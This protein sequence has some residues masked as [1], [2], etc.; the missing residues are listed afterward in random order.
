MGMGMNVPY[1]QRRRL[2][3]IDRALRRS[4]PGL[5]AMLSIFARLNAD[6]AIPAWEQLETGHA[7]NWYVLLWPV[8]SVAFLVVCAAG[9]GLGASRRAAMACS[10]RRSRT[11]DACGEKSP[12]P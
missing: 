6:E 11:S 10:P 2:R 3:R 7:P 5:A 1:R 9:G 4:D 12:F 8:A